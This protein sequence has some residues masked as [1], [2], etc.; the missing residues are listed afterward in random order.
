MKWKIFF[1]F[2]LS[3]G[4]TSEY[5]GK[6]EQAVKTRELRVQNATTAF[7]FFQP[8]VYPNSMETTKDGCL[9]LLQ[10]IK[11]QHFCLFMFYKI[12]R[13]ELKQMEDHNRPKQM[14]STGRCSRYLYMRGTEIMKGKLAIRNLEKKIAEQ[15]TYRHYR[16]KKISTRCLL[17]KRIPTPGYVVPYWRFRSRYLRDIGILTF[18]SGALQGCQQ[19]CKFNAN[20]CRFLCS[21][22]K[23]ITKVVLLQFVLSQGITKQGLPLKGPY[24]YRSIYL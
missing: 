19:R 20:E 8:A 18:L 9:V 21:R 17:R 13:I 16:S 14:K 4:N 12:T 22:P 11:K 6:L 2:S 7:D 1:M 23:F 5:F 15:I 24:G 3:S 10:N